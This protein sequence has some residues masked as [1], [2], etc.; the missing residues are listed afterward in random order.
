M[1]VN[2]LAGQSSSRQAARRNDRFAMRQVL[3]PDVRFYPDCDQNSDARSCDSIAPPRSLDRDT[4]RLDGTAPA[5][6]LVGNEF[7][8][9]L[10]TAVLGWR[11]LFA[12]LRET[13]PH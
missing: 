10:R 7:T 12:E 5:R 8:E 3:W 13:L 9:I 4:A 11:D 6:N 2:G 1:T